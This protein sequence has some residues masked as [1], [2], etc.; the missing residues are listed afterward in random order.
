MKVSGKKYK[1]ITKLYLN[2]LQL[3]VN[4]SLTVCPILCCQ[5]P[6]LY[7]LSLQQGSDCL[8]LLQFI[9]PKG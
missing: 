2:I 6:C 4:C 3:L 9:A 7:L 1:D 8:Y 5:S